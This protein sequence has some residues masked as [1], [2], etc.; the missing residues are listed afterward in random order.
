MEKQ[1]INTAFNSNLHDLQR[2]F[3][4]ETQMKGPEPLK[5]QIQTI[6]ILPSPPPPQPQPPMQGTW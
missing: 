5:E 4:L 3:P 1:I 2:A 6:S